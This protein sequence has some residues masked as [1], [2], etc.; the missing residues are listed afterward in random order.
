MSVVMGLSALADP[1]E[2]LRSDHTHDVARPVHDYLEKGSKDAILHHV[3][4]VR[5]GIRQG[6]AAQMTGVSYFGQQ[7]RAANSAIVDP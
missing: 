1:V 2:M 6:E 7:G 3:C 4:D 5:L